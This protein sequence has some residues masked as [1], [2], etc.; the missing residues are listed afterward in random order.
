MENGSDFSTFV[1]SVVVGIVESK[2]YQK[3]IDIRHVGVFST[4]PQGI[5]IIICDDKFK[6]EKKSIKIMDGSVRGCGCRKAVSTLLD[7]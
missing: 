4:F 3:N 6:E 1:N 2:V 5:F 7:I